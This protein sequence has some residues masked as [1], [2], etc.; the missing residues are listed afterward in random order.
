MA[1]EAIQVPGGQKEEKEAGAAGTLANNA[2]I[3]YLADRFT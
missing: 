1:Y 3:Q 2:N